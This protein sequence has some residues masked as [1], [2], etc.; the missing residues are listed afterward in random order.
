MP[1]ARRPPGVTTAGVPP[2]CLDPEET[3]CSIAFLL[4]QEERSANKI[5]TGLE[6]QQERNFHSGACRNLRAPQQWMKLSFLSSCPSWKSPS[7]ETE[8]LGP[9]SPLFYL[10]PKVRHTPQLSIRHL[11]NEGN[12]TCS[13]TL[14]PD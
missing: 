3:A 1:P 4:L 7:L 13:R 14:V 11:L 10:L 12:R 5:R 2:L 8:F 6:G 9:K